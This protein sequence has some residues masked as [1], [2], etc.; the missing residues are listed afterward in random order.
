[1]GRIFDLALLTI[2]II[3][4]AVTYSMKYNAEMAADRVVKLEA[5]IAKERTAVQLLKAE[6][7][8]LV[9]PARLQ[10]MVDAHNNHFL[11]LPFT[12]DQL[13]TIDDI[14]LKPPPA[15]PIGSIANA[16]TGGPVALQ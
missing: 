13:A 16:A 15:D 11:L 3:A 10:A 5:E 14:P 6:W 4:A 7:S 9:Q 2:M 1:M 12:P 8:T